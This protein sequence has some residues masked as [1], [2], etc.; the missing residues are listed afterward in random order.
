MLSI[1]SKSSFETAETEVVVLFL[2]GLGIL[3]LMTHAGSDTE[4]SIL[5]QTLVNSLVLLCNIYI[6]ILNAQLYET[7]RMSVRLQY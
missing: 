7:S 4:Y 6:M 2:V 3:G 5:C 1:A